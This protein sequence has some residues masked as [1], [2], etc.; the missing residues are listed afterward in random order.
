MI[1]EQ[2]DEENEDIDIDDS[3]EISNEEENPSNNK[4]S[5]LSSEEKTKIE[6]EFFKVEFY[7][8]NSIESEIKDVIPLLITQ[9]KDPISEDDM[10]MG[11][12]A[13]IVTT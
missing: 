6:K 7:F 12:M 2:N 4:S 13:G 8:G 11:E 5:G 9:N 10:D 1:L 3:A